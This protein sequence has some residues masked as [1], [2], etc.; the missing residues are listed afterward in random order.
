MSCLSSKRAGRYV[1]AVAARWSTWPISGLE[2]TKSA[3]R[4]CRPSDVVDDGD[5]QQRLHVD[6]VRMRLERVP[7]EDHEVDP[8]FCDR[9]SNLLVSSERAAQEPVHR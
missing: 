9:R 6:V 7:E 4:G 5:A 1:S 3:W 8:A 2:S